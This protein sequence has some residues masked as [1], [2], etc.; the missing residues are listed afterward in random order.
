MS[1]KKLTM[2]PG[3]LV[4]VAASG[5]FALL[6]V[7]VMPPAD[8]GERMPRDNFLTGFDQEVSEGLHKVN[9]ESP[10]GVSIFTDITDLGSY[11]W[12]KQ[13]AVVVGLTLVVASMLPVL[14][15]RQTIEMPVRCALLVVAWILMM[16]VGEILNIRLKEYI[17][18]ARPPY[19][20]AAHASGYSFPSGHSMAAFIAY[21]MLAYIV[22]KVIPHRKARWGMVGGL[23]ALVLLIGF[24]RI[25]LSAHWLTDV[26]GGLSVCAFWFGL[27][28][29][30]MQI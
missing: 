19:Y 2:A 30:V 13:L 18:R 11:L 6:A 5:V 23:S 4:S 25:F 29:W 1:S 20:E 17:H 26:A 28:R 12:I 7:C 16:A 24:S 27:C 9:Q 3:L 15:G 14:R 10:L 8:G 21:G 22:I